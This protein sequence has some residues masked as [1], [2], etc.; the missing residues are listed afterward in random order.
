M[1][2]RF[3]NFNKLKLVPGIG[4]K[5]YA[6]VANGLNLKVR[7]F[8]GLIS[9]FV[10]VKRKKLVGRVNSPYKNS[11]SFVTENARCKIDVL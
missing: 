8:Y 1:S 7:K 3:K 4:L 6:S 2:S 5:F 10:A 9:I 11:P